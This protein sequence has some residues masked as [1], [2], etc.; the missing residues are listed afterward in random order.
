MVSLS[1][2]FPCEGRVSGMSSLAML[3]RSSQPKISF[4][5]L[6][7]EMIF[8]RGPMVDC[9]N[10]LVWCAVKPN[11]Q[12]L[13]FPLLARAY[14][15]KKVSVLKLV[16]MRAFCTLNSHTNAYTLISHGLHHIKLLQ[17]WFAAL[18]PNVGLG[19]NADVLFLYLVVAR[20]T[21]LIVNELIQCC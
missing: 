1:K 6:Q 2:L 19:C 3:C 5:L 15:R 18:L 16:K 10:N 4:C 8:T 21:R 20:P 12:P 9:N 7:C 13:P 11:K 14:R 17:H